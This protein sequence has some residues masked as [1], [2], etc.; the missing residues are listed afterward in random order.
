MSQCFRSI[1]SLKGVT[2]LITG[3]KGTFRIFLLQNR[4]KNVGIIYFVHFARNQC[5]LKSVTF[6]VSFLFIGLPISMSPWV[7]GPIF[8][9]ED[10]LRVSESLLLS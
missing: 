3:V 6:C 1:I 4:F 7:I 10:F 2:E 8:Q 9:L 5:I